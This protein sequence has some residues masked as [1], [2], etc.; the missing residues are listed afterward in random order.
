MIIKKKQALYIFSIC[1]M[2]Q[3]ICLIVER[4]ENKV[5]QYGAKRLF[6]DK[7]L[8]FE[9]SFHVIYLNESTLKQ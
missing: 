7:L 8:L 6:V 4:N 5:T 9:P 2:W 3:L 1:L